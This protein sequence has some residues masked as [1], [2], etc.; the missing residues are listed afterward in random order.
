LEFYATLRRLPR[1]LD[2]AG[3]GAARAD[4]A[5]PSD[6]DGAPAA[7]D[8]VAPQAHAVVVSPLEQ[9]LIDAK[10]AVMSRIRT[11]RSQAMRRRR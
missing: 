2:R 9:R 4:A 3:R 11:V 6:L 10:R 8:A 1:A 5:T 7:E